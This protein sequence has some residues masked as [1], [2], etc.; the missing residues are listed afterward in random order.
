MNEEIIESLIKL[1]AIITD[2]PNQTQR[3]NSSLM[4]EAYL[5]ENFGKEMV[6]KYMALYLNELN[7]Y[8][9]EHREILYKDKTERKM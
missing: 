8:Y 6:D 7:Y 2:Y 9:V 4:V 3:E 5:R 1:F